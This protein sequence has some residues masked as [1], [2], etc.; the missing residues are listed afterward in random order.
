M[1]H[2]RDYIRGSQHAALYGVGPDVI[3]DSLD[4]RGDGLRLDQLVAL[5]SQGVLHGD[6]CDGR[7]AEDLEGREGLE[8][9]LDPGA[10][11]GIGTRY[12]KS[13]GPH[14]L[15]FVEAGHAGEDFAFQEFK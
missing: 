10:A 12:R 5:H 3:Q 6:G 13:S 15:L 14:F 4:L 9:G 2:R 1:R 8:V 7:R 11:A